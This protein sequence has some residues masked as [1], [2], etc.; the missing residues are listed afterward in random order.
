M[1]PMGSISVLSAEGSNISVDA[2]DLTYF[3]YEMSNG[4]ESRQWVDLES[5]AFQSWI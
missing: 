2:T 5:Q 1:F 3:E 4:E